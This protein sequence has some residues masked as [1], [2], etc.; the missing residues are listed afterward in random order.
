M[1]DLNY[2]FSCVE[3]EKYFMKNVSADC[4][5]LRLFKVIGEI[6]LRFKPRLH[7]PHRRSADLSADKMPD[8]SSFFIGRQEINYNYLVIF[9]SI[10]RQFLC[11]GNRPMV[12]RR[13]ADKT[14]DVIF[15]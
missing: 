10:G 5:D 9:F 6:C 15:E 8:F 2:M 13:S 11:F 12:G 7:Q 3:H 1:S 4:K 14:A